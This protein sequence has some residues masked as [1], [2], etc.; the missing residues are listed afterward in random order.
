MEEKT[1]KKYVDLLVENIIDCVKLPVP[2]DKFDSVKNIICRYGSELGSLRFGNNEKLAER[3]F[4]KFVNK[5]LSTIEALGLPEQRE[6]A[7]KKLVQNEI[8]SA[9]NFVQNEIKKDEIKVK[10]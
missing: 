2:A 7:T 1:Y 8:Y 5:V 10:V 4:K 6:K 9:L 3:E